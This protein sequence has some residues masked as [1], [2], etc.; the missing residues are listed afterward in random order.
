MS[1]CKS[2]E[3]V[4]RLTS[5]VYDF[6]LAYC[7]ENAF[8]P[9]YREIQDGVGICSL[10]TVKRHVDRLIASGALVGCPNRARSFRPAVTA[11]APDTL[12]EAEKVQ[13]RVC[14]EVRDGGKL[15][16]D[17]SYSRPRAFPTG[18]SFEGIVDA[19]EMKGRVGQVVRSHIE[20]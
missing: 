16:I 18:L 2:R 17:C 5:Q 3:A 1:R 13:E 10:S 7:R 20:E 14:L 4:S 15:Y 8:S 12:A 19:E 6:I 9:S 11:G